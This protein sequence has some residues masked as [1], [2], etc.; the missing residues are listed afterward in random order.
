[1]IRIGI[2]GSDSSHADAFSGLCNR[3]DVAGR[4]RDA[5]VVAIYGVDPQRTAQVAEQ[6]LIPRIVQ[7]P[8][9]MI[10]GVDAVIIVFRHG[11]LH[12]KHALPFLKAGIPTFV[13]K[14]FCTT[15]ADARKMVRAARKHGTPLTSFS[16]VRYAPAT[17]AFLKGLEKIGPV[18][19]GAIV[20]PGDVKS[21]Y[22]G[23]IFYGIHAIE[24]MQEAF[25]TGARRVS[26]VVHG[27]NLLAT[28]QYRDDALVSLQVLGSASHDFHMTACGKKGVMQAVLPLT[29][30]YEAGIRVVLN[31][32]RTG[33]EPL[34][35]GHMIEAIAIGEAIGKSLATGKPC[36]VAK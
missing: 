27:G 1:M 5:R 8:R 22:G 20:G 10:G 29:G 23:F 28:V 15:V 11:G 33:R 31:M 7:D 3:K 25:G 2:I 21:E 13:D 6:N 34:P 24:L 4:V 17:V 18:T 14:P 36:A 9:E 19:A 26:A 16:T 30:C 35:H 12:C 32:V